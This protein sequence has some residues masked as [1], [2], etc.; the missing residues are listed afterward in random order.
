MF[1]TFTIFFQNHSA[2]LPVFGNKSLSSAGPGMPESQR[3]RHAEIM[4]SK[5]HD[6]V[7]QAPI[8]KARETNTR[9]RQQKISSLWKGQKDTESGT[10]AMNFTFGTSSG[11][12]K[13]KMRKRLTNEAADPYASIREA[14]SDFVAM[15]VERNSVEQHLVPLE[16][17]KKHLSFAKDSEEKELVLPVDDVLMLLR[18]VGQAAKP[19]FRLAK[20]GIIV[21]MSISVSPTSTCVTCRVIDTTE[22]FPD[23]T[24]N[25]SCSPRT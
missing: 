13:K 18:G 22:A 14:G 21:R 16:W 10:L 25:D 17:A 9:K 5:E 8:P 15:V 20:I 6:K 19:L 3:P 1:K 7:S 2:N 24:S 4:S 12:A 11:K 23:P